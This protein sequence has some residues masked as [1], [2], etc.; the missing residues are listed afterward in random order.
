MPSRPQTPATWDAFVLPLQAATER[1]GRAWGMVRHLNSVMDSPALRDTFNVNLPRVTEF[2][3][4]LGQTEGLFA[5]YKALRAGEEYGRLDAAHARVIDNELRDFRLSGAELK[6]PGRE[7]FAAIQEELAGG[8]AALLGE[9]AGRNQP[10]RA[11]GGGSGPAR[12]VAAGCCRCGPGRRRTQRP[13]RLALHAAVSFL[14]ARHAVRERSRPAR[15]RC[16]E[17]MSHGRHRDPAKDNTPLMH[18][19]LALRQEKAKLLGYESYAEVSL[20]AKMADSPAAVE[21]FL[22]DLARRA[23]PFAEKDLQ[24]VQRFAADK[25]G[26]DRLEAWDLPY[27]SEHL[28]QDRY[29]FSDNEVKQYFQLPRVLDGLFKLIERMFSVQIRPDTAETWHPDVQFFRIESAGSLVGQFYLDLYAREDEAV[30]RLDGRLP[31]PQPQSGRQRRRPGP[32]PP[33]DAGGLSGLQFPVAGGRQTGPADPRRRQHAVPRVRPRP[34][35][36]ADAHRCAGRL[37][38]LRCRMGCG[39]AAEPV[40]GELGMGV[41]NR[42][43]DE[44]ARRYRCRHAAGAV[45]QDGARPEFPGRFADAA[46][47][48]VLDVRHGT[49]RRAVSQVPKEPQVAPVPRQRL[50]ALRRTRPQTA[51]IRS[52]PSWTTCETK[53]R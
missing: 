45:R 33:A 28:K 9:R 35:P 46:P 27:A 44:P 23:R 31:G 39:R 34:A 14:P 3:T 36:Y 7:R 40:H 1:L 53:Y 29:S 48:R 43:V 50:P 24:E 16:T 6:S 49:S 4:R 17:P 32:R 51:P 18:R 52:R 30:R 12:R 2:W 5:K 20:V 13:R 42:V 19:I 41:G 38:H 26:M 8:A 10:V 21:S 25:L 11:D 37:R 22:L 47:D 15:S